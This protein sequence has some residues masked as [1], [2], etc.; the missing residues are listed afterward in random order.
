MYFLKTRYLSV[1]LF[2]IC[3]FLIGMLVLNSTALFDSLLSTENTKFLELSQ[4]IGKL[5][6]ESVA[7]PDEFTHWQTWLR[8]IEAGEVYQAIVVNQTGLVITSTNRQFTDSGNVE[9]TVFLQAFH[10]QPG[11]Q[12]I[13]NQNLQSSEIHAC[14]PLIQTD[15][16]TSYV[17]CLLQ[18]VE[19]NEHI[20]IQKITTLK[21]VWGIAIF[22]IVLITFSILILTLT[23]IR[24]ITQSLD[25]M[26]IGSDYKKLHTH[27]QDEIGNL[28]WSINK[29]LSHFNDKTNDLKNESIK[30]NSI[31]KYMSDGMI[32]VNENEI[33]EELN[34]EAQRIFEIDENEAIGL[35]LVEVVRHHKLIALHQTCKNSR[36]Q[37]SMTFE[38]I[39]NKLFLRGVASPLQPPLEGYTLL[40]IQ[41]LTRLRHL[42]MVRK[43]F[44][45]NVS[46]ELRTPIA[47]I[48]ALTE[49]L[50]EGAIDNPQDARRFLT[51]MEGE[52]DNI[53][54]MV[55]E[56]LELSRIEAGKAVLDRI[57]ISANAL[58]SK[59]HQ[60]MYLQAERAKID[61]ICE[62]TENLPPVYADPAKI[63]QVF[64]NLIHNAIKFSSPGDRII[65]SAVQ[66]GNKIEFSVADEGVG[67]EPQNLS[68]IF[69]RFYKEDV[70]RSG[71]GTGLGLT[72]AKH[73]IESHGGKIWAKNKNPRGSIFSFSLPIL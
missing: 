61:L 19:I 27:R 41:D 16:I 7:E 9:S 73:I 34:L 50:S 59:A 49:T 67:I 31:L 45:S 63:G 57:S 1:A 22:I 38:T 43:D 12:V 37:E 24:S 64:I 6:T 23:P 32:I 2:F 20:V 28:V 40:I 55:Q 70:A 25:Q 4:Q 33:V 53:N 17:F 11:Y 58:T 72:I 15:K 8:N 62:C 52:I 56:L 71:Q 3:L 29:L 68:R 10:G 21:R 48:K 42:E 13:Y 60:R 46:H 30:R 47:S 44:V 69:E 18:P 66:N 51:M 65:L 5:Q 54:Q 14:M 36:K 35:T 26:P 39:S